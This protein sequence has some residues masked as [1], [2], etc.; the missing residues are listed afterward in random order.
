MEAINNYNYCLENGYPEFQKKYSAAPA[1]KET[2]VRWLKI[3][4][5]DPK[6]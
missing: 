1:R 5:I 6:I 3:L 4:G 2:L